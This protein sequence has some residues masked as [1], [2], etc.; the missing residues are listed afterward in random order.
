MKEAV[1]I[2]E[3]DKYLRRQIYW[4]LKDEYRILEA[5]DAV[6]ARKIMDK[7]S[8]LDA[9]LLDLHLPPKPDTPEE[10]L[11]LLAYLRSFC[12]ETG[13]IVMT[14]SRSQK[15]PQEA[16]RLGVQDFFSKPFDLDELRL[17]LKRVLHML[18]LRRKVKKIQ[19]ELEEKYRFANLVG[20]SKKMQ[21]LFHLVYKIAPTS[22]TVLIRGESGTGKELISRA[23]HSHSPRKENPFVPVNCAALPENLLEVELFG[24]EKGAFTD[25][26]YKKEGMFEVADKGTI[27]LDEISDMSLRMQAKILRVIQERSFY[28]L[29][30]TKPVQVDVRI[31]AATNKDLEEMMKKGSFRE[32]LYYRLNVISITIPPLRKRKE[33]IPLLAQHF[34]TK[35]TALHGKR[36]RSIS[37]YVMD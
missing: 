13:V 28:R 31:L 24:H 10:G 36:V 8:P 29:G 27:F 32:D 20:K 15:A 30:G 34:L 4:A 3:D 1:L 21:E 25:A 14:G 37:P 7:S 26:S 22:C 2:I 6:S 12:S 17:T 23:I 16:I 11:K 9:V 5:D 19:K 35:Y 18:R 33:D